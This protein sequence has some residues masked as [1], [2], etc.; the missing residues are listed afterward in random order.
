MKKETYKKQLNKQIEKFNKIHKNLVEL[1]NKYLEDE[2]NKF[3]IDTLYDD[4]IRNM[5]QFCFTYA[6]VVDR[7]QDRNVCFVNGN[8]DYK[9]SM[10]KKIRKA[11]GYTL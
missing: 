7:L 4:S 8:K 10:N 5:E 11:L 9:K 2:N 3:T 1:T 6:W